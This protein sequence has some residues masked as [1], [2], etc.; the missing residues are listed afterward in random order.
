MI[1]V[2]PPK[3]GKCLKNTIYLCKVPRQACRWVTLYPNC[4]LVENK[5]VWVCIPDVQCPAE[6][7][8]LQN[9]QGAGLAD[10]NKY[11]NR[12]SPRGLSLSKPTG[13]CTVTKYLPGLFS[14]G[15]ARPDR[16]SA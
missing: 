5:L 15:A 14:S 3:Y 1:F 9:K 13:G 12:T 4:R 2:N 16:F 10:S 11:C 7:G 8:P 6:R